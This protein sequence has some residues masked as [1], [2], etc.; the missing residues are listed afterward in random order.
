[1]DCTP[2]SALRVVKPV[3]NLKTC[4]KNYDCVV[5]CPRNAIS[6]TAAGFPAI[7]YDLCDGCLICLRQCPS[8][9]IIEERG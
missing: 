5:Y 9:A 2:P 1:M 3:I 7:A 6:V 8:A 4:E